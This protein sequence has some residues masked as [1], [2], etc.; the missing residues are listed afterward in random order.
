MFVRLGFSVAVHTEPDILLVDE[1]LSVG[2]ISFQRKCL[3]KIKEI[4]NK[5]ISIIFI[6]HNMYLVQ[7]IC[8]KAIFLDKGKINSVGEVSEIIKKYEVF[9]GAN[10]SEA[11]KNFFIPRGTTGTGEIEILDVQFKNSEGKTIDSFSV[12]ESIF[13][14]VSYFAKRRILTPVFSVGF[15][16]SDGLRCGLSR[17]KFS[18]IE[19]PA[20]EGNGEFTIEIEKIQLNSG[21]YLLEIAIADE[22]IINPYVVRQLD[23]FT[24]IN[25]PMP[26]IG[27]S[28]G[29][30][31]P[32]VKWDVS[33]IA[34]QIRK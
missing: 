13:V 5:N 10:F 2:D 12:G 16:R 20:I 31:F 24:I 7:A 11:N 28:C 6:A 29:I 15:L 3:Q 9:S 23:T 8:S 33:K 34:E 14:N 27:D 32:M 18:N 25:P 1:V 19:I 21:T 4:Q 17:T 22:S 30:Y 26:N